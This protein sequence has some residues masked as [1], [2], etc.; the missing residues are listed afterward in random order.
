M[1]NERADY[2]AFEPEAATSNF[3]APSVLV[4]NGGGK[5]KRTARRALIWV[6][7][8][9]VSASERFLGGW[10]VLDLDGRD[11]L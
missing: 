8:Q 3:E 10:V 2:A 11:D 6:Y 1:L 4:Q 9:K 7:P 5:A